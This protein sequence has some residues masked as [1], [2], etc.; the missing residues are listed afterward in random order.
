MKMLHTISEAGVG[1][2]DE[3]INDLITRVNE[4]QD[5]ADKIQNNKIEYKM[6]TIFGVPVLASSAKMF[7]DF[8]IGVMVMFAMLQN[9]GGAI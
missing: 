1:N 8:C 3:Q 6:K 4:M 9:M 5:Q 2:S 7:V